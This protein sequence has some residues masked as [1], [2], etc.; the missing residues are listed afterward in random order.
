MAHY[1]PQHWWSNYN[2][3]ADWIAMI[4]VQQTT[5]R[6]TEKV[7]AR[8][9]PFMTV[10]QLTAMPTDQL[11]Q[12]IRPS[13]FYHQKTK[14]IRAL[15]QWYQDH[16]GKLSALAAV[17]TPALRKSLLG[18]RGVGEETADDMLL[19]MFNRPVFVADNYARKLFARLG[20]GNYTTYTAMKRATAPLM[21]GVSAALA[22][23][24][25]AVIDE[26][27]KLMRR[28]ADADESWLS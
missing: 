12:L 10:A 7:I 3:L 24:W 17:P 19:Y 14:A 4:L 22:Q 28:Q 11:E 16:G 15:L 21:T 9:M 27:G 23:D 20:A 1:G 13:G 5:G 8:M 6:N 2:R 26:H 25:H 18:I